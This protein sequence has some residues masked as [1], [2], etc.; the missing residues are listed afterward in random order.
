[1]SGFEIE[2]ELESWFWGWVVAIDCDKSGILT[3]SAVTILSVT[4][5]RCLLSLD[6][7]LDAGSSRFFDGLS[8]VQGVWVS[9]GFIGLVPFGDVLSASS[10]WRGVS[11]RSWVEIKYDYL[12]GDTLEILSRRENDEDMCVIG[13][14]SLSR[15]R[16]VTLEWGSPRSAPFFC[17]PF[18]KIPQL[19]YTKYT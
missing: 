5:S 8:R 1:M 9:A 10:I 16:N 11:Q 3:T 13:L 7:F 17:S 15:A 19:Y 12:I 2:I 14:V 4:M 6:A 18:L